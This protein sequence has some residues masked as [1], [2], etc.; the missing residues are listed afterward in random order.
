[1]DVFVLVFLKSIPMKGSK[2]T[3]TLSCIKVVA[4]LFHKFYSYLRVTWVFCL[5]CWKWYLQYPLRYLHFLFYK[6]TN[7]TKSKHYSSF[8]AQ[9]DCLQYLYHKTIKMIHNSALQLPF[10]Y[11]SVFDWLIWYYTF[12]IFHNMFLR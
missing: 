7:L 8:I 6:K 1:M 10:F 9:L 4:K 2:S 11:Y 3:Q 12:L 5:L